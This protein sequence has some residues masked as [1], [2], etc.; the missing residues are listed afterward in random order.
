MVVSAIA[1]AEAPWV[2][3]MWIGGVWWF[4]C[5]H[6]RDD[7]GPLRNKEVVRSLEMRLG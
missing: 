1:G 3:M 7:G 6:A 5:P 2:R 4:L